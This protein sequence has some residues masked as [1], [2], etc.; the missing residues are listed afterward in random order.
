MG[1]VATVT[2]GVNARIASLSRVLSV[3]MPLAWRTRTFPFV[4]LGLA[5]TAACAFVALRMEVQREHLLGL[6]DT[7]VWFTEWEI[8]VFGLLLYVAIGAVRRVGS[9]FS[10]GH[11]ARLFGCVAASA[12]ALLL[13]QSVFI[14]IFL[15]RIAGLETEP[16]IA[17]L[18]ET[19]G[20]EG[21]WRC[22]E[23]VDQLKKAVA[24]H[25][26]LLE[27]DL[28]RYGFATEFRVDIDPHCRPVERNNGDYRL[29]SLQTWQLPQVQ[30]PAKQWATDIREF[31][32]RLKNVQA[33][34]QYSRTEGEYESRFIT[35]PAEIG[36]VAGLL[37]GLVA[38]AA[39]TSLW[40]ASLL[41]N[42][43]GRW[44]LR[45]RRLRFGTAIGRRFA[46][47]WPTLWASAIHVTLPP[48][49]L[50]A[51]LSPALLA[52]DDLWGLS[53]LIVLPVLGASLFAVFRAQETARRLHMRM[54]LEIGVFLIHLGIV[55][56]V[57]VISTRLA[58]PSW[59]PED[60]LVALWL[61]VVLCGALQSARNGSAFAAYGCVVLAGLLCLVAQSASDAWVDES[62]SWDLEELV[63]LA[64]PS[65][66]AG[67][68]ALLS[69]RREMSPKVQRVL[70][71]TF[72]VVAPMLAMGVSDSVVDMWLDDFNYAV[73]VVS[74]AG[75]VL[76]A[77]LA[78]RLTE[79]ARRAL[80]DT[81]G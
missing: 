1:V 49:L 70:I 14:S 62:N 25:R 43:V 24:M 30:A 57:L 16:G 60:V 48:L 45:R 23:D 53:P 52:A 34:Q 10:S 72:L 3:H 15:S 21:F 71:G 26:Y 9:L 66:C 58:N 64:L 22:R 32:S 27:K 4:G 40:R 5:A 79:D 41:A 44:T 76:C 38:L 12:I 68:M 74:F 47:R 35:G 73:A 61:S 33:A 80:A 39:W 78:L 81:A 77:L 19:H 55:V 59:D 63:P 31:E 56:P 42:V 75:C 6:G 17:T 7:I 2:A 46:A 54:S 13:P 69:I 29:W 36:L 50:V 18:V 20:R 8:T 28:R 11:V 67:A 51:A 37:S 65:I